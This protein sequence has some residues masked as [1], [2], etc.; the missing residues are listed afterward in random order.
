MSRSLRFLSSIAP[1]AM[2]GI[3]QSTTLVLLNSTA[4]LTHPLLFSTFTATA[5]TGMTAGAGFGAYAPIAAY[6][7]AMMAEP[8]TSY[9]SSRKSIDASANFLERSR[10]WIWKH[11]I[12]LYARGFG[13]DRSTLEI[14]SNVSTRDVRTAFMNEARQVIQHSTRAAGVM[15]ATA[16][17]H[18]LGYGSAPPLGL[19]GMMLVP[20]LGGTAVGTVMIS[21]SVKRILKTEIEA[22]EQ[23]ARR[24]AAITPATVRMMVSAGMEEAFAE[25]LEADTHA[26]SELTR[27]R[28]QKE[29][30]ASTIMQLLCGAGSLVTVIAGVKMGV[31][32]TQPQMIS[33]VALNLS[34][35]GASIA[36]PQVLSNL[37]MVITRA[38]TDIQ[39]VLDIT[40]DRDDDPSRPNF[41]PALDHPT[42][43][44]MNNVT[45]EHPPRDE[46]SAPFRLHNLS[47]TLPE[48]GHV[49]LVGQNGSGKSTTLAILADLL[50]PKSGIVSMNGDDRRKFNLKSRLKSSL[51]VPQ[52]VELFGNTLGDQMSVFCKLDDPEQRANAERLLI[53][54]GLESLMVDE[55]GDRTN[56]TERTT[57]T[58][59]GKPIASGGQLQRLVL[60]SHLADPTDRP[61]LIDEPTNHLGTRE[62]QLV[63]KV[64]GEESRRRCLVTATQNADTVKRREIPVAMMVTTGPHS[65]TLAHDFTRP[66][67]LAAGSAFEELLEFTRPP[68]KLNDFSPKPVELGLN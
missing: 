64:L 63:W 34:V 62:K 46:G 3:K 38:A 10:L 33:L 36:L 42:T 11:A 55:H 22:D 39:R 52:H 13:L 12:D 32:V 65:A 59:E 14:A 9:V 35:A 18:L 48:T 49:A 16:L 8:L 5:A 51:N 66:S 15:V 29:A 58:D 23:L 6:L 53:D 2:K 30:Q 20:I 21:K 67:D 45:Y 4:G 57:R 31:D 50:D 54:L 27:Q 19:T 43:I 68:Q 56:W 25:D 61:I 60:A 28:N 40:H 7:G 37:G 26:A 17:G 41:E 1:E 44:A 24:H 47:L